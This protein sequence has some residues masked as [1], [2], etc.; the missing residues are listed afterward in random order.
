MLY[1]AAAYWFYLSA[2]RSVSASLAATA[3]Y[4]IPVFG[5]A[6]SFVLLGERL[7][8][9]QWVGVSIVVLAVL[10][11]VR[12]PGLGGEDRPDERAGH[13]PGGADLTP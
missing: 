6:A 12:L 2:L 8:V 5:V 10:S 4:L 1:Y 13:R 3:F 7:E 9:G 11:I